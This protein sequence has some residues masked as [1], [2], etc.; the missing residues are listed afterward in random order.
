M[1]DSVDNIK[2]VDK[3]KTDADKME[4]FRHKLET[5][6]RTTDGYFVRSKSEMLIHNWL[7]MAE[8]VHT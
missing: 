5:T 4:N 2:A 7:Y 1:K 6:H 3:P 8:I